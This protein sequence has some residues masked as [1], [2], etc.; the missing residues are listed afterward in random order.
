MKNCS[1][2]VNKEVFLTGFR[3]VIVFSMGLFQA[4]N[5]IALPFFTDWCCCLGIQFEPFLAKVDSMVPT[6]ACFLL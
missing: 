6:E 5:R 2:W 3:R 1:Y 4:R